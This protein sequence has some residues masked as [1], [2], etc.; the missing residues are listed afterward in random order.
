MGN[1]KILLI[2][3]VILTLVLISF[4][5]FKYI[6][7]ISFVKSSPYDVLISNITQESVT[8]S[9]KTDI[10]MPSY[11]RI[12]ENEKLFGDESKDQVH[13]VVLTG[14]RE[15]SKYNFVISDGK[16]D[17]EKA[18]IENTESL[19]DFVLSEYT[20]STENIS[21]EIYIPV[22]EELNVLPQEVV[23]L[24]LYDKEEG[25]Y[26]SIKTL[27]ANRFG[28]LAVDIKSFDLDTS[29][30]ELVN[31][32]YYDTESK[33]SSKNAVYAAEVNCNQNI[34]NQSI[35]GLTKEQ[36]TDLAN[37]WVAGRGKNYA[38]ECFN[39]V[40]YRAKRE[41]V[42][43]A[44]ALTIWL[45]ES[46]ASNYTQNSSLMGMIEDF[47][48]HGQSSAPP[49]DFNAQIEYFLKLTY[50]YSCPGLSSWEAWG[51]MYRWGSCN[52]NDPV[53]R[54]I[55]IDYYKAIESVYGLVTNGRKLPSQVTGLPKSGGEEG[56]SSDGDWGEITGPLCCA[57]KVSN[58]E[59]LRGDFENNV[60]GKSC[61]D[62][63][64][65]GRS[66]YGGTLE[67]SVEIKDRTEGAC[68]VEYD[69][70]CCQLTNDIKWYPKVACNNPISGIN[71]S[72]ECLDLAN[73]GGCFFREAK[74]QW[75][76]KTVGDDY[77]KE[78]SSKS[79]CDSRNKITQ[80]SIELKE[81][82]N[83]VGFDFTPVF[84]TSP[85][86]ASK[87]L[88]L[89]ENI[90]LIGDF[91]GYEWKNL[92]KKSEKLPFA[93]EDFY[94]EQGKGYLVVSEEDIKIELDGWRDTNQKYSVL[95]EGWNLVGGSVYGKS[96]R[97]S[98]LI[99]NLINSD[100][101]VNTVAVWSY[102]LGRFSYRKEEAQGETY[103]EDINLVSN[104]G[105][106]LKR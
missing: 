19:E 36:F 71:T 82:V 28:G 47:G 93:G 98:V 88:S 77:L 73:D 70:V 30:Y 54:Q 45:N 41:G 2:S 18:Y 91:Q 20:F 39:D 80:Y 105:I 37:R 50:N 29:N 25:V 34:S 100:I 10:P 92:V 95:D 12:G 75:L 43:P 6:Q 44:F 56:G 87:L 35:D 14:L 99:S 32:N 78:V 40:I 79:Q 59:K 51:N 96:Y 42:D 9:W 63:W 11:I 86:Y 57:L 83:F 23:Y 66:V 103:G 61:S 68:E 90:L 72:K 49:Q 65:T 5:I 94:F 31:I 60:E 89:N 62:I 24:S 15:S 104:Q 97:A 64:K 84:Q 4:G 69:G 17:W 26:S 48:I 27:E 55:G 102:E 8:I 22:V 101:E 58:Q 85:L 52:E 7:Y 81:G 76:P 13:R 38:S 46:G 106:F 33:L 16:R 1:K 67:Y 3:S 53:K 21:D 74:Y